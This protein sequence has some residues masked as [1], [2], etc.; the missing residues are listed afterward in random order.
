LIGATT[1]A[2]SATTPRT[3]AEVQADLFYLDPYEAGFDTAID[4]LLRELADLG[5]LH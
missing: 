1:G 3:I 5:G 4:A 2:L